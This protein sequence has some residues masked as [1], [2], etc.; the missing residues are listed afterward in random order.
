M[1]DIFTKEKRSQIMSRIRS[2]G[3]KPEVRLHAMLREILGC[4]WRIDCHRKDLPGQPDVVVPSL[5]LAIFA[6]G[7]FYHCCPKH[8]HKPKSNR[9]YWVPKLTRN[10][11]RDA[12]NRRKLRRLGFSVWRFWEHDLK[13]P[14]VERTQG[15]IQRRLSKRRKQLL[16]AH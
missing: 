12:A 3:T 16:E 1:A 4:R 13:G 7:C 10:L 6:D 8:G 11:R 14:N 15:V 2:T 5:Q 9:G